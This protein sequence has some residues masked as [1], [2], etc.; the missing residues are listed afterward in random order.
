MLDDAI[1][2]IPRFAVVGWYDPVKDATWIVHAALVFEECKAKSGDEVTVW[3][4]H[5]PLSFP[6][7]YQNHNPKY[8]RCAKPT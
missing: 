7:G 1:R 5:P 2:T 6:L 3:E 4:M 8:P